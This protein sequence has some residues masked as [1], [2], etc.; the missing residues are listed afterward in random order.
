MIYKPYF[1]DYMTGSPLVDPAGC[2]I[3]DCNKL[4]KTVNANNSDY[5]Q[6]I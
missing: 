1:I 6:E 3:S 2:L 5:Q 4:G